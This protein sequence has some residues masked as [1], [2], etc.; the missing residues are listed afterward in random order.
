[1]PEGTLLLGFLTLQRLGELRLAR[2]NTARLRAAGA[3]EVGAGH[4]PLIVALHASWLATLW[5]LGW[6]ADVSRPW[7]AAFVLLQ[8]A[9]LWIL[10][11]LKGRWTTRVLVVPGEALVVGGPF[12][13]MRHPN[14]AVVL[15]EFIVVP[16]ALGLVLVALFFTILNAALL[17][18]RIREED[19]A[20]RV[21]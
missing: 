2:R 10:A 15:A 13:L 9:R 16:M 5:A 3:Y 8:L 18:W 1:M 11:T 14:Y 7:L 4:Y 12:R 21:S 17:A 6:D 19:R 20:L